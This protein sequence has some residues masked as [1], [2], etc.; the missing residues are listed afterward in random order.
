[1]SKPKEGSKIFLMFSE[2]IKVTSKKK[3]R[4]SETGREMECS[5]EIPADSKEALQTNKTINH[6][7]TSPSQTLRSPKNWRLLACFW[8]PL[9]FRA[10]LLVSNNS[11]QVFWTISPRSDGLVE[12]LLT[13][14]WRLSGSLAV[15]RASVLVSIPLKALLIC[16]A[17]SMVFRYGAYSFRCFFK[18]LSSKSEKL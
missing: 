17:G 14:S 2:I 6:I 15:P 4:Q 12:M 5:C 16:K 18:K 8:P 9:A 13:D 10:D 3:H 7:Q 11:Y 1:M